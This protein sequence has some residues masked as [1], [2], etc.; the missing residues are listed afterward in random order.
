MEFNNSLVAYLSAL[1]L[2]IAF[3]REWAIINYRN[4]GGLIGGLNYYP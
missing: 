3:T 1:S 4:R 2:A